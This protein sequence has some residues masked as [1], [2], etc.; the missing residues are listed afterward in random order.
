MQAMQNT[1]YYDQL[2][3]WMSYTKP[4]WLTEAE[5]NG[6]I[7]ALAKEELCYI[8]TV[9]NY[10]T[11]QKIARIGKGILIFGTVS[12]IVL[13]EERPIVWWII[14]FSILLFS[15]HTQAHVD[16]QKETVAR[17]SIDFKKRQ[18]TT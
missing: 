4:E 13:K 17:F 15:R 9:Y 6:V 16:A 2:C 3:N 5:Q 18:K 12:S 7:E 11:P 8:G 14:G 10:K 1:G